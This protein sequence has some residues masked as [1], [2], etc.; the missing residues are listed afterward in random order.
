MDDGYNQWGSYRGATG[1]KA[2]RRQDFIKAGEKGNISR[3][4]EMASEK[5]FVGR[6]A[7]LGQFKKILHDKDGQVEGAMPKIRSFRRE[8]A[9]VLR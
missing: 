5:V 9:C 4:A 6:K 2:E 8:F 1:K 7:E 3:R